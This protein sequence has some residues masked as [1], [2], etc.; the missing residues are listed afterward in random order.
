MTNTGNLT[1]GTY[2][3]LSDSELSLISSATLTLPGAAINTGT[4][5]LEL[6]SN[7]GVLTT[8]AADDLTTS[9]G[10]ITLFGSGG[11]V[12]GGDITTTLAGGTL[13]LGN[14]VNQAAGTIS[15]FD[16]T[17]VNAGAGNIDL[18]QASNDFMD[19]VSLNNT[20][21]FAVS[22]TDTNALDFA[23]SN[24][25]DSTLTVIAV[26]ITQTGGAIIQEAAE[27]LASFNAGVGGIDLSDASN[28]FTGTLDLTTAGVGAAG[29]ITLVN[30]SALAT[31][32]ITIATDASTQNIDLSGTV[33]SVDGAFSVGT[34]D[35]VVRA[36]AGAI[37]DGT[38]GTGGFALTA[39]SVALDATAG[40]DVSTVTSSLEAQSTVSGDIFIENTGALGVT[41]VN[42]ANGLLTTASAIIL[43]ATGTITI[44]DAITALSS[45]AI[46]ITTTTAGDIV[47]GAGTITT[48]GALVLNAV[49]GIGIGTA[50]DT[51]IGTLNLTT[52]GVGAL[53]DITVTGTGSYSTGNLTIAT[54][55][56]N[57]TI[58]LSATSWNIDASENV[59]T[60]NLTLTATAGD[61]DDNGNT[62]AILTAATLTLEGLGAG[63]GIGIVNDVNYSASALVLTTAGTGAAGDITVT[64]VAAEDTGDLTVTT[65]ASAQ[66]IDLA[67]TAWTVG[68]GGFSVGTDTLALVATTGGI[69]D[70]TGGTGGNALTAGNLSFDAQTGDID[71]TTV[72]TGML[73]AN[74][75]VTGDIFIEN[76]GTLDINTVSGVTGVETTAST[77]TIESTGDITIND[78]V[79][80]AATGDTVMITSTGGDIIG[81]T[82]TVIST[83]D[84]DLDAVGIGIGTA[85][86][87]TAG[88]LFLTTSGTGA[89]G[90]ITVIDSTAFAI[91][92]VTVTTAVSGQ[93]I[94]LEA[95]SWDIDGAFSVT[96]NDLTL[97]STTG[98]IDDATVGATEILTASTLTLVSAAG[99]GTS[100]P[101]NYATTTLTS[102][103]SAG[104]AGAGNIT[105][106]TA[107]A[108]TTSDLSVTTAGSLQTIDLGALS[109]DV[110][111]AFSVG[112]DNLV[113]FAS[114]GD[115]DD[116]GAGIETGGNLLTAASLALDATGFVDANI[117]VSL[118]AAQSVTSGDVFIENT[119][120][121]LDVNTFAG[122]SGLLTTASAI[123]L[124]STGTI[125]I[126]DDIT[127]QATG[128]TISITTTAGDI[129][130]GGGTVITTGIANLVASGGIG[131]GTPVDVTVGGAL[132]LSAAATGGAADIIIDSNADIDIGTVST[133]TGADDVD[134]FAVPGNT[135][136]LTVAIDSGS[137][138]D[139]DGDFFSFDAGAGGTF[140][141]GNLLFDVGA[142]G[143]LSIIADSI[144]NFGAG[145]DQAGGGVFLSP[146]TTGAG[147]SI[148]LGDTS[149]AVSGQSFVLDSAS[150]VTFLDMGGGTL[151]IG[152]STTGSVII[153]GLDITGAATANLFLSVEAGTGF[154]I[155]D[156]D[157]DVGTDLGFTGGSDDTLELISDGVIG[158][159][160]SGFETDTGTIDVTGS[161]GNNV[162]ITD[163]GIGDTN[164]SVITGGA[165][166]IDLDILDGAG[167]SN[168][169]LTGI[170]TTSTLNADTVNGT[171]T[172]ATTITVGGL[173]TF[174]AGGAGNGITLGDGGGAD[175]TN[176]GTLTFTAAGAVVITEDSDMDIT[177][178]NTAGS[179]VL[180]SSAAITD[181]TATSTTITGLGTFSGTSIA[182]GVAGGGA[183]TFNA[184]SLTFTSA[185]AVAIDEDS[186]MLIAGVNTAGSANLDSTAT[187]DDTGVTSIAVT[188]L[189]DVNGVTGVSLGAGTFNTGTL[190]FN[191]GGSVSISEDSAID[192]VGV[193]TANNAD[194]NSTATLSD[195]GAT[196]IA[197][198]MLGEFDG[199][200]SV[201]LGS[202]GTFN[203]GTLTFTSSGAVIIAEDSGMDIV[204]VNT[205]GAGTSTLSS[206]GALSDAGA[207]STTIGGLCE[208]SGTSI[209]LG[210]AGGGAPV[211][212]TG[213]LTFN[214]GGA[215]AIDED[216]AMDIVGA[217]TASGGLTLDSTA[218]IDDTGATS[219]AVTGLADVNG[220]AGVNLGEGGTFDTTTLTFNSGGAVTIDEDSAMAIVGVNTAGAGAN[221]DSTA[222]IDDTGAT[223]IAVTGLADVNGVIGVNL[224]AGG[225]FNTTTLTFNSG[226]T[227]VI[228]E[229]TGMD[230]VGVNTA[231]AGTSTLSST[232]ALSDAG[233]TSID[234]T[235]LGEFSGTTS[236]TLGAAGGGAPTF[237]TGT[238]TFNSGGAVTIDEDSS[239]DIVGVNT[240]GA[241]TSTFT[242]TATISDAGA[243]STDITG[244]G[245]FSGTSISLG[246]AGG[247]APTF[248]AGTLTF[249]SAGAVAIDEDSA[250]AIV[251]VNTAGGGLTLDSTATIDDTGATSIAVTGLADVNGVTGVNLG[252]GAPTFNTTTLDL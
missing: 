216:S 32:D 186:G 203:T 75:N 118:L 1:L 172:D 72:T 232:G 229:D 196:S 26:G 233:S 139:L 54:N 87:T 207:T 162:T 201:T 187:I 150:V 167:S 73:A 22:I 138:T 80:T 51:V 117:A 210:T 113:L 30:S 124:E 31:N 59:G 227:V 19:T 223:S 78:D 47:G 5:A 27:G 88:A 112:T 245:V 50:V 132:N 94:D 169:I 252:A 98:D 130:G 154:G 58:D 92:D 86:D 36:S 18:T 122:V 230:I 242:S 170:S 71:V 55:G 116:G 219:I 99:I 108:E 111:G 250:M 120:A 107:A 191:S 115:I 65:D 145:G 6:R 158:S 119:S 144:I 37:D 104:V 76:T 183:P 218:T 103:T 57:Q 166:A 20:G 251:G 64:T 68:G 81:G 148:G 74:S 143:T 247:G 198:T 161:G 192:I 8:A 225:T 156:H 152:D 174:N 164:F 42:F 102:L 226:G 238:L 157:A 146:G 53:G 123:T 77:I 43:D 7:G 24:I 155:E 67:A 4:K 35:L 63:G 69:S 159:N 176:F 220:V 195:A 136:L 212:N 209:T 205:A 211:F 96:T 241:G 134:I 151:A 83:G 93:T 2:S 189:A 181:A 125:T 15:I 109:W 40:I 194:I 9:S 248:N 44:N 177:G 168:M 127:T 33:F 149:T 234:I 246:T 142:T 221:L 214:S 131:I 243:T 13:S 85:V 141:G 128:S 89:A 160:T 23:T 200:T 171:I 66:T 228:A 41:A 46:T 21:T 25:G 97:R 101:I 79:T 28:D 133:G 175:T 14:A 29:D 244:L 237:N 239:M 60:D 91:S 165:G 61:I 52:A 224:G 11:I 105:A 153:D 3:T 16:T 249:I 173:A 62:G 45:G 39:A 182:L 137:D 178:V 184:G 199:T 140:N 114:G 106:D 240:A 110:D 48:A 202:G 10:A 49:G 17:T 190:T 193:N 70:G 215:V 235:G 126:T 197:V 56:S 206:T 100:N 12:I 38:G 34:D 121:G 129:V 213:T 222:T 180:T 204:G 147:G 236:I 135:I 217:N 208:F 179:A 84:V 231:G 185:G 188:G 90:N 95:D 82:G 163:A